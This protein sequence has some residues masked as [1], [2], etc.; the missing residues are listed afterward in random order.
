M[1]MLFA[2]KAFASTNRKNKEAAAGT[3]SLAPGANN[4]SAE[5]TMYPS[6][7]PEPQP[8]QDDLTD[9]ERLEV[10]NLRIQEL[11]PLVK[12]VARRVARA[13]PKADVEELISDG[14]VGLIRS[15]DLFDPTRGVALEAYARRLIIG[16]IFNG[17][18][19]RDPLTSRVRRA[20][21][22]TEDERYRIASTRGTLP[23]MAEME[24]RDKKLSAV[25]TK[26]MQRSVVSL[27]A[28]LPSGLTIGA[29]NEKDPETIAVERA[30]LASALDAI[31]ALPE[32]QRDVMMLY[33]MG[34]MPLPAI[35]EKLGVTRQRA[36]QIHREA[37]K[38]V[39]EFMNTNP[40]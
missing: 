36:S 38:A 9:D 3:S 37:L 31:D 13:Y 35:A 5:T 6:F 17:L 26:A 22:E 18:R 40:G 20:L 12:S 1:G 21:R 30:M 25:R 29:S 34:N 28:P 2:S 15:V 4:P 27:D 39:A 16:A 23:T 32:R 33:Y 10:R 11:Y 7:I 8:V 24:K 19:K 14:C